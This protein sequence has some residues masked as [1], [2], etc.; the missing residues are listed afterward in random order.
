MPSLRDRRRPG[1]GP[2]VHRR[3]PDTDSRLRRGAAGHTSLRGLTLYRWDINIRNSIVLGLVGAGGLGFELTT[4]VR[5][6]QYQE[7]LTILIFVF[8][9]VLLVEQTSSYVRERV[10]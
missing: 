10:I 7:V 9:I 3:A 2:E 8:I 1:R 5:L 4:S 6:F